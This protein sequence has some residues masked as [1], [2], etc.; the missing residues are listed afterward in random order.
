M[1]PGIQ[2]KRSLKIAQG[3]KNK[4]KS[5][6]ILASEST[7][8]ALQP[9]AQPKREPPRS[10]SLF[11]VGPPFD[12]IINHNNLL[13]EDGDFVRPIISARIDRGFDFVDKEWM[14]YKRNYFTAV[15]SFKF[16]GV[17]NEL[18]LKQS[19]FCTG[20][21]TFSKIS[22]VNYFM[23]GLG[24]E[25]IGPDIA[26]VKLVQHTAKRD[27]GPQN[28]PPTYYMIPGALPDHFVI[29]KISNVRNNVKMS[30]SDRYFFLDELER[31]NLLMNTTNILLHDYPLSEKISVAAKY[32][33]IQFQFLP[34]LTAKRNTNTR[35]AL[36]VDLLA[37]LADGKVVKVATVKTPPLLI[38]SR[39]PSTY[40]TLTSSTDCQKNEAKQTQSRKEEPRPIEITK[41]IE[42]SKLAESKSLYETLVEMRR[43]SM[44]KHIDMATPIQ[45]LRLPLEEIKKNTLQNQGNNIFEKVGPIWQKSHPTAC[46][47][48]QD[49]DQDC[50]QLFVEIRFNIPFARK[51]VQ[52][53]V[54]PHR[55][56]LSSQT[57]TSRH[58]QDVQSIH[59]PAQQ[60]ASGS[61]E[62]N[63]S[64]HCVGL[65]SPF[66]DFLAEDPASVSLERT[67]R[68]P[69]DEANGELIT[70]TQNP[71]LY[72]A[73][74]FQ[75]PMLTSFVKLDKAMR[76]YETAKVELEALNQLELKCSN[77]GNSFRSGTPIAPF[78]L[79]LL[80]QIST[81]TPLLPPH[82]NSSHVV[83]ESVLKFNRC[84]HGMKRRETTRIVRIFTQ[85]DHESAN[86]SSFLRLTQ[87]IKNHRNLLKQLSPFSETELTLSSVSYSQADI[88][89]D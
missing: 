3:I 68:D 30:E 84:I 88:N 32:D 45:N 18:A 65:Q 62:N 69:C 24:C 52:G 14:G 86:D 64:S 57:D 54:P 13:L 36:K 81:S 38:R 89:S 49:K 42:A 15:V 33:R 11:K 4:Q 78:R 37:C 55:K 79:F 61:K 75:S 53:S 60:I 8:S 87:E 7:L 23:M 39:S 56:S 10:A 74:I 59:T 27:R 50:D 17:P 12:L 66:C 63:I 48:W 85:K 19:F 1:A 25:C 34:S 83:P 67:L 40:S 73:S 20:P 44:I 31:K 16:F 2:K 72:N 28:E 58:N 22:R 76:A 46:R 47:F 71:L 9:Q 5:K 21:D 51:C 80:E 41:D 35:F 29:R 6:L 77:T 70:S 43:Q 26:D 82:S